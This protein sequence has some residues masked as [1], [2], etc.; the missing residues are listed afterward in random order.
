LHVVSLHNR[1]RNIHRGRGPNHLTLGP[2]I[3]SIHDYTQAVFIGILKKDRRHFLQNAL[4]D[5]VLL[6]LE[7]FARVLRFPVQF[8]LLQFDL[9]LQAGLGFIVE[10]VTLRGQL[11][12]EAFDFLVLALQLIALG[13]KFFLQR[14]H[15]ALAFIA[16]KDCPFN[17]DGCN[18]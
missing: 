2:W 1:L 11:F 5:L 13:L 9:P 16:G 10:L 17:V 18:F 3:R 15:I 8:L 12:F 6:V 4:A 7:I 14:V